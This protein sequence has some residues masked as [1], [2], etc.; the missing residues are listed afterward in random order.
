MIHLLV[1]LQAI[2]HLS[3]SCFFDLSPRNTDGTYPGK[4][5]AMLLHLV[6]KVGRSSCCSGWHAADLASHTSFSFCQRLSGLVG[7]S[8]CWLTVQLSSLFE[9]A[10][11]HW[12][13]RKT[14]RFNMSDCEGLLMLPTSGGGDSCA[15]MA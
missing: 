5:V 15:V 12:T 11:C 10:T 2:A 6:F 4:A 13:A 1:V 7:W 14:L 3:G 9:Q 8:A